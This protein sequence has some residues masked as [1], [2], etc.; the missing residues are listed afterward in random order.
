M[1]LPLVMNKYSKNNNNINKD[2][3]RL[4]FESSDATLSHEMKA[5][6]QNW[7]TNC[8]LFAHRK[9]S[10]WRGFSSGAPSFNNL[11]CKCGNPTD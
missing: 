3:A 4:R 11:L 5:R 6:R 7:C 8:D 9:G 2:P 1:K 10:L